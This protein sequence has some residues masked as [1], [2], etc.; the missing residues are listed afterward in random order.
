MRDEE[1]AARI[2]ANRNRLYKIAV[3]YTI[4]ASQAVDALDEAI[5]KAL[6]SLK[7]CAGRSILIPG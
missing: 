3:M 4:S 5:Y 7:N 6:C 2:E 1:F